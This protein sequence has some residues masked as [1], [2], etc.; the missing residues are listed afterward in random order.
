VYVATNGT[1][2]SPPVDADDGSWIDVALSH[3]YARGL[4]MLVYGRRFGRHDVAEQLVPQQFVLGGAGR[5]PTGRPPPPSSDLQDWCLYRAP[6]TPEE[7]MAQHTGA[8]Q[9]ASMEL[10]A[11]LDDPAFGL[12]DTPSN[13][14]QSL[15]LATV[16]GTNVTTGSFILPPGQLLATS[17]AYHTVTLSWSDP[18]GSETGF[19]LERRPAGGGAFWS[20]RVAVAAN[21]TN[22]TEYGVAAGNYE[23]RVSAQ[24]GAWQSDY[25]G[26]VTI[27]VGAPPFSSVIP[28]AD[29]RLITG[30]PGISFV[31]SNAVLYVLQFSTNLL[32]PAGW[33]SVMQGGAPAMV[34]GN[35]MTTQTLTDTNLADRSR[36]YRLHWTP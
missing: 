30:S 8:L 3:S 26:P 20:N 19:V 16:T 9:Q 14:A 15:S 5:S 24:E 28:L 32:D 2:S 12:G 7:A 25:A 35:G 33:Q 34:T 10:C 4:T 18:S 21:T 27:A 1:E 29:F 23:Y 22:Y 11:P 6:W 36:T 13:R 31:G 17:P